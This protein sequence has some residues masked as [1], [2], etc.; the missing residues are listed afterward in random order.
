MCQDHSPRSKWKRPQEHGGHFTLIRDT[1]HRGVIPAPPLIII[2]TLTPPIYS[3]RHIHSVTS[4]LC[5]QFRYS[6]PLP[7]SGHSC[8]TQGPDS[9]SDRL[10]QFAQD[11]G[12]PGTLDTKLG[13]SQAKQGSWP[14]WVPLSQRRERPFCFPPGCSSQIA[15]PGF[16]CFFCHRG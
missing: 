1:F 10:F 11:W 6:A 7:S 5:L 14:A 3:S 4:I 12:F 15:I 8:L 2:N 9:S 13:Q 16:F